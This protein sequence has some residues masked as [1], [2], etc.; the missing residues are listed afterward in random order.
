MNRIRKKY[1]KVS[2]FKAYCASVIARLNGQLAS[3]WNPFE[4]VATNTRELTPISQVLDTYLK[5]K[6]GEL[7][8]DTIINYRSFVKLFKAWTEKQ[9]GQIAVSGFNRV[10]AVSFMEYIVQEKGLHGR[11]YNNRLKQARAFFTY[12]VEKY[13]CTENPFATIKTKREEPK[14]RIMIPPDV[15]KKIYAYFSNNTLLWLLKVCKI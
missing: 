13:Y 8:P 4:G 1:N 15:R 3:G 9:Y 6:S 2:D 7:R 5:D 11:S 14:K 12:A 10:M